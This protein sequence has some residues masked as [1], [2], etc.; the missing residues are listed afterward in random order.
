MLRWVVFVALLVSSMIACAGCGGSFWK[1][2]DCIA[3]PNDAFSCPDT[4][5]PTDPPQPPD[6]GPPPGCIDDAYLLYPDGSTVPSNYAGTMYLTIP[7]GEM[8]GP[9]L[10]IEVAQLN[11]T[12]KQPQSEIGTPLVYLS[13]PEPSFAATPP[14]GYSG[15]FT[16]S[17]LPLVP[18]WATA[19]SV[20]DT[21]SKGVCPAVTFA[22]LNAQGARRSN[23]IKRGFRRP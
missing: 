14:P 11:P 16:S 12:T 10:A 18:T 1:V 20:V 15:V 6:T 2:P 21:R 8:A 13:G 17:N 23:G 9:F 19:I 4:P 7:N 22:T 3:D 5:A